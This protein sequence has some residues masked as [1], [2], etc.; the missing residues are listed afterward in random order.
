[1]DVVPARITSN[2]AQETQG[3]GADDL[4]IARE[5][6]DVTTNRGLR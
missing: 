5:L 1:L 2:L 4:E 3:L 6:L